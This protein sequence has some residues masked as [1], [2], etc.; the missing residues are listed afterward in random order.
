M[1]AAAHSLDAMMSDAE[2]VIRR[3]AA[4]VGQLPSLDFDDICQ[5]LRILALDAARRFDPGCEVPWTGFLA[6]LLGRRIIDVRR[7]NG[8]QTRDG[9]RRAQWHCGFDAIDEF[10][11]PSDNML[12]PEDPADEV[13]DVEWRDLMSASERETPHLQVMLMRFGGM[14][15]ADIGQ[16]LGR[17]EGRVC[18]LLSD[19]HPLREQSLR[20]LGSML[21][22]DWETTQADPGRN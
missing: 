20:R 12:I 13:S 19:R 3:Y 22:L 16:R 15:L 2:P 5:E 21:G 9:G 7:A 4:R 6:S 10:G 17:T 8:V 18:Q 11:T 1:I 14:T